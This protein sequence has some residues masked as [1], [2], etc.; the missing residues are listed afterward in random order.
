MPLQ[1]GKLSGLLTVPSLLVMT[2]AGP[3]KVGAVPGVAALLMAC[4]CG[5]LDD[6]L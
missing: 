6:L 3:A 1:V 2:F 5:A 4:A